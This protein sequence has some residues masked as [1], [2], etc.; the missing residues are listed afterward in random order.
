M[1]GYD[2][3]SPSKSP[4]PH[5]H[6]K[7]VKKEKIGQGA[8]GTVY[9]C[10]DASSG[11]IVAVKEVNTKGLSE[12]EIEALTSEA[13]VMKSLPHKHIV[14]YHGVKQKKRTLEIS[15]EYMPGGSLSAYIR[16]VGGSLTMERTKQY[17]WQLVRAVQF[18]HDH[19]IAHRDIKSANVLL[20]G[21]Q[22]QIKL[23]DFGA[24]KE[25][26]SVSVV[27]GLKGTPHWMAPEVIKEQQT[28]EGWMKADIW[29]LG[30][31]VLEM[32]TGR[33]PWQEYSNPL[34]AMYKIVSS[35]STPKVPADLP[36]EATSFLTVCFQRDPAKRP[37]ASELLHSAFLK[38]I[39]KMKKKAREMGADSPKAH[40]ADN[41]EPI[42][43][44]GLSPRSFYHDE[45]TSPQHSV[46][47][48]MPKSKA[49]GQLLDDKLNAP[50]QRK[51]KKPIKLEPLVVGHTSNQEK[52]TPRTKAKAADAK[53]PL[54]NHPLMSPVSKLGSPFPDI[55][56]SSP[57]MSPQTSPAGSILSG[58]KSM[59][60]A[61]FPTLKM[62]PELR[63]IATAP[64]SV[65]RLGDSSP[66]ALKLPPLSARGV[67]AQSASPVEFDRNSNNA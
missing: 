65:K 27:G 2:T 66:K 51:A 17:T 18:L 57:V 9:R 59:A 64:Q 15:M 40:E 54:D 28:S 23:A 43:T 35:E 19:L 46:V 13:T 33:T 12:H 26:G 44:T 3:A 50:R 10:V 42:T 37:T 20:S 39:R 1:D 7:W 25:I 47:D 11:R 6:K 4:T 22:S 34:T 38:S 8:Q 63:R 53:P 31:T 21:D 49:L 16:A 41:N 36:P 56:L 62:R 32:L 45:V 30:C 48:S 55:R 29:S 52:S 5:G 58:A 14:Q 60:E 67:P 61:G 24:L